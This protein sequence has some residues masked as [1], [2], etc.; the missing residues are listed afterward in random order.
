MRLTT[1][2]QSV[3]VLSI[4]CL[5]LCS[6]LIQGCQFNFDK[7]PTKS[8]DKKKL[9]KRIAEF[10]KAFKDGDAKKLGSMTTDNYL[11]TNGNSKPIKK[12]D[13]LEYLSKRGEEIRKGGLIVSRYE[14]TEM[15]TEIYDDM[16]IVTGKISSLS[17]I[18]GKENASMI[19]VT[20]VWVKESNVWKRAGFHDTRID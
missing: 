19:R 11:H 5:L 10:N 2:I 15:E 14:L 8:E 20:N 12:N 7:Q 13:W 4:V 3:L 9:L 1:N 6:A 17:I 16:A 18:E